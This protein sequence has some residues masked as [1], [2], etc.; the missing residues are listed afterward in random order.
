MLE[1]KHPI[2]KEYEEYYTYLEALRKSG[3]VNMYGAT[4]YLKDMYD[5]SDAEA[6]D[7][8]LNWMHN[9]QE[10]SVQYNWR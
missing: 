8:L 5:L 6:T 10:L 4:P 3:V 1:I 7:V 2:K 9:Y